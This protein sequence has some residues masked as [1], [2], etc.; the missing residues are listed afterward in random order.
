MTYQEKQSI[1][2]IIAILVAAGAYSVFAIQNGYF[3]LPETDIS[4]MAWALIVFVLFQIATQI[5]AHIILA[6]VEAGLQA[7]RKN[8][9]KKFDKLDEREKIVNGKGE[10]YGNY[11][12]MAL[13]FA[14]VIIVALQGDVSV[15]F[16][17]IG[18][19]GILAGILSEALKLYFSKRGA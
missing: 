16:I 7:G 3:A 8:P 4:G 9:N 12:H 6:T 10:R 17:A 13:I 5:A 2:S 14:G 1:T 19:G 18:L 11:A 15:L